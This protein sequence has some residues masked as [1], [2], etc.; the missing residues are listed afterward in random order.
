[1]KNEK[2]ILGS[3]GVDSGQLMICDPCYLREWRDGD[4]DKTDNHYGAACAATLSEKLGGEV[5][6]SGN[7]RRGD[8]RGAAQGALGHGGSAALPAVRGVRRRGPEPAGR[9]RSR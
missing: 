2:I 4:H 9:A 3:C 7:P 1:M 5:I 6:V 8:Q